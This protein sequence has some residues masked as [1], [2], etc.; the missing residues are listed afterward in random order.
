MDLIDW[1]KYLEITD[2]GKKIVRIATSYGCPYR[3]AFCCE[4]MNS[5]RVWRA[6]SASSVIKYI[7]ALRERV[8][9]DGLMIVDNNFFVDEQRVID[10]CKGLIKNKIKV[11]FGQVNGRTNNLVRY[12]SQTWKLMKKAGFYNILIGAESGHEETLHFIKK[13]ATV[14]DTLKLANIC[15][16]YKIFLIVSVIVGLP[17]D[18]YFVDN[19]LAFQED[20]D[21]VINLYNKICSTGSNHHLLTFPYAPLPFSPL[22]QRAISLGF[23]PP[24]TIDDWS[25]YEFTKVHVPWMPKDGYSKVEVLNYISFCIGIDFKY[26]LNSLPAFAEKVIN[27]VIQLF[28]NIGRWRLKTRFFSFPLDMWVF[29]FCFYTFVAIN[30]KFRIVNIGR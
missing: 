21:G 8:D 6:L 22:Y 28:K 5:K 13:D 27:P 14:E 25:N 10:I 7:K 30:R 12:K 23:K 29:N 18:K 9:F 11:K 19:K 4:P 16:K 24:V 2:F 15:N 3:C 26:L 1:K 17:T 20:L